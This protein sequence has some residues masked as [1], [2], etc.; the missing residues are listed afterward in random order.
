MCHHISVTLEKEQQQSRLIIPGTSSNQS[1]SNNK[2]LQNKTAG[3]RRIK[4]KS[5][6]YHSDTESHDSCL[7]LLLKGSSVLKDGRDLDAVVTSSPLRIKP[8]LRAGECVRTEVQ[9]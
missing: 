6:T 7:M 2:E 1:E 4:S 3:K 9:I 8:G 5:T